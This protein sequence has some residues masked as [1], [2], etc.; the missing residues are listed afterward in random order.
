MTDEDREIVAV[1]SSMEY[2][3]DL[4]V[5]VDAMKALMFSLLQRHDD[6][7]KTFAAAHPDWEQGSTIEGLVRP[8]GGNQLMEQ[9]KV[10][11]FMET[12]F[13]APENPS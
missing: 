13:R 11:Y 12:K 5:D 4:T 2:S 7:V 1:E 8:D 9:N 10:R 6:D 3:Q